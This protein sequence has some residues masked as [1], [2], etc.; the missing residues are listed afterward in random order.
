[1][2][3]LFGFL[4]PPD[5]KL[6]RALAQSLSHRGSGDAQI[7]RTAAGAVGYLS[8][9]VAGGPN[10]HWAG[11]GAVG[12]AADA[13]VALA[14]AV[15]D[16]PPFNG[17]QTRT[18][19]LFGELNRAPEP[20]RL[21][22][23]F[24]A[25]ALSG[26]R[27]RLFRDGAGQRTIYYGRCG[28]RWAFGVEP[29]AIWQLPQFSRRLRPPAIAQYL[30]FSF[31]PGEGTMLEGLYELPAGHAVTLD[32]N[33][34]RELQRLFEFEDVERPEHS[35]E[36]WVDAFRGGFRDSVRARLPADD[37]PVG[38][39]LSGGIDSSIVAAEVVKHR[40]SVKTFAIHFGRRYPDEL[41][42]AR[43]VAERVGVG[44]HRE[45]LIRPKRFLGRL[46]SMIWHLDEPIGDPITMPNYELA[47]IVAGETP[48]VFNG[49]GGDPCYGGPKNIPLLVSHW[50]G[51][52]HDSD[53]FRERAYLASYRRGYEE[54]RRLLSPDLLKQIDE[55]R[56]LDALVR[57][58][59]SAERPAT[60]LEKML[61][62]NIRLKGA[63]LILPKVERM[64]AASGVTPLSP[65]F[66]E[67]LI[68]L[69]F[70]MPGRMKL[71]AGIEKYVFKQ[72]FADEL[73]AEVLQRPKS[74]MRVPVHFWFRGELKRFARKVLSP[75][76]VKRVGL[77]NADRV[78]QLLDYNIEEGQGRY[79]LRLWMLITLELWRRMVLEGESL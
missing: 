50:Y 55:Q 63:H 61:A 41:P 47:Q 60:F 79:G 5:E 31:V 19:R 9:R 56:D 25:A 10:T 64:L 75:R 74:G 69:A 65:L 43:A 32:A 71:R 2:G 29:K 48:W 35:D 44:E 53:T 40:P 7:A 49:E 11:V 4:G 51:G 23:A 15:T 24:V 26:D 33:G 34:G 46:R 30:T 77:F 78:K 16:E 66:D 13:A 14:G 20:L 70:Q 62:I 73:P 27:L 17:E 72:A 1:M 39:F 42:F 21:Q 3:A 59:F 68:R 28:D 57:P 6:I 54:L 22:G 36:Y 58:F 52:L 38:L 76:E 8:P 67:R 37:Q 45:I 18:E 12:G